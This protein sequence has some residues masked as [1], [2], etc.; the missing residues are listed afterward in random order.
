M[1]LGSQWSFRIRIGPDSWLETS[2]FNTSKKQK[3]HAEILC[4]PKH[5]ALR[6]KLRFNFSNTAMDV[7]MRNRKQEDTELCFCLLPPI[8]FSPVIEISCQTNPLCWVKDSIRRNQL[9]TGTPR[10]KRVTPLPGWVPFMKTYAD[11]HFFTAKK[12]NKERNGEAM[13]EALGNPTCLSCPPTP[14]WCS[15][16]VSRSTTVDVSVQW[17]EAEP[18]EL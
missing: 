7:V 18:D 3:A 6:L 9:L 12:R 4:V 10:P 17:G 8:L 13:S 16:Q 14:C 2:I 5:K 1:V 15:R 11:K